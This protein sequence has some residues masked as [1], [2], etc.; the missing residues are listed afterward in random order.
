MKHFGTALALIAGLSAAWAPA[1]LA[2]PSAAEAEAAAKAEQRGLAMYAYDQAALHAADRFRED[3]EKAGGIEAL[4]EKGLR[5]YVVEPFLAAFDTVFYGE[6]DG[7]LFALA[8]YTYAQGKIVGGGLLGD[9]EPDGLSPLATRMVAA[10]GKAGEAMARPGH[11]LCSKDPPN[12]L[13]LLRDDGGLSVYILTSTTDPKV[14]PAGGHYRFDFDAE[15]NMVHE[16]RFMTG[17][18]PID[19]GKVP[20]GTRPTLLI[21]HLLDPQ[22][23]EIHSFISQNVPLNLAVVTASN[24]YLWMVKEGGITFLADKPPPG[25]PE[26]ALKMPDEADEPDAAPAAAEADKPEAKPDTADTQIES[27]AGPAD[28]AEVKDVPA[29]DE[30]ETDATEQA[31]EPAGDDSEA[32]TK[33]A[34]PANPFKVDVS[35]LPPPEELPPGR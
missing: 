15:G 12:S 6:R 29:M 19:L 35:K 13:V 20:E 5:G 3:A 8:R 11:L 25:I 34:A 17:C 2:A 26:S 28:Q 32:E 27:G 30:S 18:F 14:Y 22:P 1:A 33:D 4:R 23:T 10:L 24:R 7:K 21:T 31:S 16:R 9:D